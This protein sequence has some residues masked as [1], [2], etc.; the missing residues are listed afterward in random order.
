MTAPTTFSASGILRRL[1]VRS[2]NQPEYYTQA[3]IPMILMADMSRSY[4][5]EAV[6]GR[7]MVAHDLPASAPSGNFKLHS[8]GKGGIVI[9]YFGMASDEVTAQVQFEIVTADPFLGTPL[10][11]DIGGV[12]TVSD[13]RYLGSGPALGASKLVYPAPFVMPTER[14]YV[15]AGSWFHAACAFAG[16]HRVYLVCIWREIAESLG[17][18]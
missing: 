18:P 6:E 1:G 17:A 11:L 10:K 16:N 9:E 7:G 14:V 13:S 15:P 2:A 4:A 8:R 5:P 12:A 3:M